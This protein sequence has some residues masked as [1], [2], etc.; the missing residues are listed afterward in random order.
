MVMSERQR[1]AMFAR[2]HN[3]GDLYID[4]RKEA[5]ISDKIAAALGTKKPSVVSVSYARPDM[6]VEGSIRPRH[7]HV[8]RTSDD[9]CYDY[10]T[11][12]LSGGVVLR[13]EVC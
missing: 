1:K 3:R 8:K 4:D 2:I 10:V 6:V 11:D 7:L 5:I 13:H 12:D 9:V